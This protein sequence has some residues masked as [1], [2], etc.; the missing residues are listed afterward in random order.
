MARTP[1]PQPPSRAGWRNASGPSNAVTLTPELIARIASNVRANMLAFDAA[2]FEGVPNPTFGRWIRARGPLYDLL[3]SELTKADATISA[4]LSLATLSAAA[5]AG[6]TT[7]KRPDL[8]LAL[9]RFRQKHSI[10]PRGLRKI[11]LPR[12]GNPTAW[13]QKKQDAVCRYI[14]DG[15]FFGVACRRAGL[16]PETASQW[17]HDGRDEMLK[18]EPDLSYLPLK[19]FLSV[20]HAREIAEAEAVETIAD[21]RREGDWKAAAW[22]LTHGPVKERWSSQIQQKVT[23]DV[24]VSG[25]VT[26]HQQVSERL[27]ALPADVVQREHTRI[28]SLLQM[29]ENDEG[30]FEVT[31]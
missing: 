28:D 3:R 29:I 27:A 16:S 9:L 24:H 15:N 12:G 11:G 20:S 1:V 8:A 13:T 22:W 5:P 30:T 2:A 31:P 21:A 10:Q 25:S 18:D 6:S 14:A 7:T 4:R 17:M 26:L 19:F 23:S